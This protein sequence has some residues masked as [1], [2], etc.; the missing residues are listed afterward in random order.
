MKANFIKHEACPDCK[1]SDALA[2]YDDGHTYCFSC[3]AYHAGTSKYKVQKEKNNN[4][5]N[6]T[7]LLPLDFTIDLPPEALNWLRKYGITHSDIRLHR[8]GWSQGG[9]VIA[10]RT[11]EPIVYAP[12]LIFPIF[13]QRDNLLMWQGRYFGP[14]N[15]RAPKYWTVG[16]K[17][18]IIHILGAGET[19]ILVEDL[20]SAIRISK[21]A[22]SV[23]IF[24]SIINNLL[25]T[26]LS[27]YFSKCLIWLDKDK[28]AYS[29]GRM[30]SMRPLFDMVG[31]IKSECDPKEYND[32]EIRT[33]IQVYN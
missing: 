28:R 22:A 20:L 30:L 15:K 18:E 16:N 6:D 12:L 32:E 21:H 10:K 11:K 26:R 8:F 3:R 19:V 9:F 25:I 31:T 5:K 7:P 24:G 29:E 17:E 23:P 14:E 33:F 1:S 2:V 13:D 4:N 27:R